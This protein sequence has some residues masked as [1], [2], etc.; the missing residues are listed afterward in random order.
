[1]KIPMLILATGAAAVLAAPLASATADRSLP[2]DTPVKTGHQQL[3]KKLTG[4]SKTTGGKTKT[5]GG[6][7]YPV[8]YIYVPMP[9]ASTIA[10]MPVDD[11][12]SSGHNCTPQELCALWGENC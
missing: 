8:T 7:T 1:M 10:P 12:A 4:G 6:R 2:W 9:P 5:G 11:C 3:S